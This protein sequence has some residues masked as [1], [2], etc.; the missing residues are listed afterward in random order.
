MPRNTVATVAGLT[1]AKGVYHLPFLKLIDAYD[2]HSLVPSGS[3]ILGEDLS[4]SG[5]SRRQPGEIYLSH[6]DTQNLV[7]D[8]RYQGCCGPDGDLKNVLDPV[9]KEPIAYEFADCWSS[10]YIRFVSGE[11]ALVEESSEQPEC[12]VGYIQ[13]CGKPTLVG[14]ACG[15]NADEAKE[16]LIP[17]CKDQ[18]AMEAAYSSDYYPKVE[19]P[20]ETQSAGDF[21]RQLGDEPP[22]WLFRKY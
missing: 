1:V 21:L 12:L 11:Y 14:V 7:Y 13:Y 10:H 9:T 8:D 22:K 15:R 16:R 6:R 4:A 19:A 5:W 20:L 18:L 3:Y 2:Q 17:L